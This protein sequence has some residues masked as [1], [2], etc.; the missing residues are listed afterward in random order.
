MRNILPSDRK[1]I[2]LEIYFKNYFYFIWE[3]ERKT[4]RKVETEKGEGGRERDILATD[5]LPKS[6]LPTTAITRL[7]KVNSMEFNLI[8]PCGWQGHPEYTLTGS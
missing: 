5:L 7:A 4:E 3:G 1:N 2:F 6:Q 8:L